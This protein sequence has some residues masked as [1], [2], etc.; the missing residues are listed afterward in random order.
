MLNYFDL[1]EV[2]LAFHLDEAGLKESYL[3]KIAA[4]H[5]DKGGDATAFKQLNEAY[6][7]LK[8]PHSRL[9]HLI[10]SS[11][12]PYEPRGEISEKIMQFFLPVSALLQQVKEHLN[13]RENCQSS[14]QKAL[15][16]PRSLKLQGEIETSI[17][18]LEKL[19]NE[20]LK[21]LDWL[22]KYNLTEL[23]RRTSHRSDAKNSEALKNPQNAEDSKQLEKKL[24]SLAIVA[25]DLAFLFKW[26]AELQQSY[27]QLFIF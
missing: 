21:T 13:A 5:P 3:K 22:K 1:L 15:L 11:A 4:E 10:E 27:G 26:R 20:A 6:Q 12:I 7:G 8:Y 14:L 16:A 24:S 18:T 23:A 25:R 9:R 2:N 17:E 19:E